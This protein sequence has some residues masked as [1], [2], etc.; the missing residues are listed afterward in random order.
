MKDFPHADE[1][2]SIEISLKCMNFVLMY[3]YAIKQ[4][5]LK[6]KMGGIGC[7]LVGSPI[8]KQL[9][10]VAATSEKQHNSFLP[11]FSIL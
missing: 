8:I 2:G 1:Q 5:F 10:R 11:Y 4:V 7:L 3:A 6:P 9:Q